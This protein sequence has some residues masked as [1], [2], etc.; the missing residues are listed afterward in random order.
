MNV[1][2]FDK[3]KKFKGLEYIF[4]I[5]SGVA[6]LCV[7][8]SDNM[9]SKNS[10]K[11]NI[12][13]GEYVSLLE[14]RLENALK[15]VDGAGRVNVAI[16]VA[17]GNKTVIATDV[18]TIKNGTEVQITETPILVGGKVVVLNELY[19]EIVG[20]VIVASGADNLPV[21]LDLLNATTTLLSIGDDKVQILKG[22]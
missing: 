11:E 16:S 20:V 7:M 13:T 10:I 14:S 6:I 2:I 1:K 12:S 15:Q 4:I 18:T 22:K 8:M 3:L 5:L 17:G 21:R 19:P 9:F